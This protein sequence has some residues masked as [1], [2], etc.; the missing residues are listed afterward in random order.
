[1]G[2]FVNMGEAGHAS[3]IVGIIT[4]SVCTFLILLGFTLG[5]IAIFG[6]RHHGRK[7]I[8]GRAIAGLCISGF[9]I[10]FMIISIPMNKKMAE[11]AK[12]IHRQQVEQ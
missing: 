2:F 12:E 5:I 10:T 4:G 1:M 6:I 9:L 8:L 11:R 3:P 7:G